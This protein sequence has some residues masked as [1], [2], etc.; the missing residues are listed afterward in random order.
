MPKRKREED[1]EAEGNGAGKVAKSGGIK[2]Q[3]VAYK[4]Q[5]GVRK[6]AHAFKL[7]K[8]FERQKLSRRRKTATS[9]QKQQD[10]ERIDAEIAALKALDH[11]SAAQQ[12]VYK[13]LLKIKAVAEHS[14]LPAEAKKAGPK[15]T[16]APT[17]NVVARL[18]KSN[19][20]KEA[21][22]PVITDVQNAL[23]LE[24]GRAVKKKRKRAKDF[25]D[26][27]EEEKKGKVGEKNAG[28]EKKTNGEAAA[29]EADGD[30]NEDEF[31]GYDERIAMSDDEDGIEDPEGGN[32]D[33]DQSIADLE[34]QLENE[35]IKRKPPKSKS[36]TQN[37]NGYDHA[38]D[39]SLSGSSS[40]AP[41]PSPEPQKAPPSKSATK[42]S[43]LPTLTMGGYIS[44][45]GS[46]VEDEVDVAPK[47]NRRGQRA[48]QQLW[49]KKYGAKAK[50]LQKEKGKEGRQAGWD[51]KRGATDGSERFGRGR[52]GGGMRGR[53]GGGG[54][55]MKERKGPEL[56]E[57]KHRDD[58]GAIHPSWEAAK[59]A[60]EK[61]QAAPVAFQGKKTTFD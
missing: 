4:L 21:L 45:S 57:K 61:K 37:T 28:A 38:A 16:D 43:F 15:V 8:G 7:A 58:G 17:L 41:S 14:D 44:G 26:D 39:L 9:Q 1:D 5:Q 3:R 35:G 25:E 59:K 50:H 54:S 10:V 6:V 46:E 24:S 23:G 29:M 53:G 52:G 51:A 40:D 48:R 42:S 32:S 34:R 27:N 49:E 56:K 19:Q 12:H 30:S 20:A 2:Q 60:K 31:A 18:C 55:E 36:T 22:A 33:S 11:A 47:K 13:S